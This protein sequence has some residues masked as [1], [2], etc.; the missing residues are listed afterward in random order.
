MSAA[1][2]S[3]IFF[4]RYLQMGLIAIATGLLLGACQGE[5]VVDLGTSDTDAVEQAV[6]AVPS[7]DL[8]SSSGNVVNL[9]T[10]HTASFNLLN[11]SEGDTLRLISADTDDDDDFIGIRPRVDDTDAYVL[12]ADGDR[13][14]IDVFTQGD[15]ATLSF[16]LDDTHS[17]AL[18]MHLELR[19]SLID[20]VDSLGVYQLLPVVRVVDADSAGTIEGTLADATI[21]DDDCHADRTLGTGVAIY[22]YAGSG[23]TPTDYVDN[24][25]VVS[26]TLPIGSA[27]A[28][29]DD[30]SGDW[31]YRFDDVAPGTY[32]LALTCEADAEDPTA[33]DGL[34]FIASADATVETAETTAVDF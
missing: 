1:A 4:F 26:S 2:A 25:A 5:L 15:Y 6:L 18:A 30:S 20:R 7:I 8:L 19:F 9:D 17:V 31:S 21:E 16:S 12:T 28:R 3:P 13:I 14:P 33:S 32:T 11:Y 23:I 29:H 34:N 27:S 22:L 24:G 10:D